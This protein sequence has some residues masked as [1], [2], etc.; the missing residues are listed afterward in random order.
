VGPVQTA[1]R[2]HLTDGQ[3]LQTP[4]GKP[5]VLDRIDERGVV[6]LV[7]AS[8]ASTRLPWRALEEVPELFRDRGWLP[9]SGQYEMTGDPQTLSGHLKQY[10]SRETANWVAVTLEAAG[11]LEVDRSRPVRARLRDDFAAAR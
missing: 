4:T 5:F 8:R 9:T 1:V 3:G 7:G 6:L 10:V 2:Q 11:V